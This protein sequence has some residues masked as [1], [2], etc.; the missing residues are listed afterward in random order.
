M[1]QDTACSFCGCASFQ[2]SDCGEELSVRA[3]REGFH[4]GQCKT[5]GGQHHECRAFP[6][7]RVGIGATT[8]PPELLKRGGRFR[9]MRDSVMHNP[10]AVVKLLAKVLVVRCECRFEFDSFEYSGFSSLFDPLEPN[11][12]WP[13]YAVQSSEDDDKKLRL[14]FVKYARVSSETLLVKGA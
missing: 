14:R 7:A 11:V 13:Y 12:E 5:H 6:P 2:C 4:V 10:D 8:N 9:V 1:N 3:V